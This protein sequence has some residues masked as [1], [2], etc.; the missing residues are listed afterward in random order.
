MTINTIEI[1]AAMDRDDHGP[2]C[3]AVNGVID[4][5]NVTDRAA[6]FSYVIAASAAVPWLWLLLLSRIRYLACAPFDSEQYRN[7]V[8]SCQVGSVL[9]CF[10]LIILSGIVFLMGL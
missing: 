8:V 9:M 4:R 10:G 6:N 3:K 1:V 5:L 2:Q 7:V